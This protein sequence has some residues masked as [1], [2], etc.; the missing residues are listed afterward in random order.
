MIGLSKTCCT[1]RIVAG[2]L[3]LVVPAVPILAE[4]DT[5]RVFR[6]ALQ[7]GTV[8]SASAKRGT[9]SAMPAPQAVLLDDKH[10]NAVPPGERSQQYSSQHIVVLGLSA[11]G[12]EIWRRVQLDPRLLRAEGMLQ[13]DASVATR[14]F[15]KADV[16]FSVAAPDEPDVRLLRIL[17]PRWTGAGYALDVL[18][19]IP[20]S[21]GN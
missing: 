8:A 12:V 19:E 17:K 18:A 4:T 11:E 13:A 20:L 21:S 10:S 16:Q 3:M 7:Q 2:I 5:T 6:L 15:L 1:A 14:T 9:P